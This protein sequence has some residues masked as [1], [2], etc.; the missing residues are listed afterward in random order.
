MA[1][2]T[3]GLAISP[4]CRDIRS[5]KTNFLDAPAQTEDDILDGSGRV[6]CRRTMQSVGPDGEL[7]DP[8]DCRRGRACFEGFGP[9]P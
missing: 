3:R 8:A 5:K 7:V 6:W 2:D 1:E 9:R 4:F